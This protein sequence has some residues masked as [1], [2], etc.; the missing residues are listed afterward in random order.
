MLGA[1]PAN[2]LMPSAGL[3]SCPG[4]QLSP[5]TWPAFSWGTNRIGGKHQTSP[6]PHTMPCSAKG[7]ISALKPSPQGPRQGQDTAMD[8]NIALFLPVASLEPPPRPECLLSIPIVSSR[9]KSL[10]KALLC[11]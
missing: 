5:K 10:L 3:G 2:P 6:A 7:D 11:S 4:T 8:V 9:R 1:P